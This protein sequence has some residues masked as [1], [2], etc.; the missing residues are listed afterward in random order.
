MFALSSGVSFPTCP[1]RFALPYHTQTRVS[2][3]SGWLVFAVA[4]GG[5]HVVWCGAG[6]K[7]GANRGSEPS[8]TADVLV[9]LYAG[10]ETNF[11][12]GSGCPGARSCARCRSRAENGDGCLDRRLV[13]GRKVADAVVFGGVRRLNGESA[14]KCESVR[15]HQGPGESRR[16]THLVDEILTVLQRRNALDASTKA[17][18]VG[19]CRCSAIFGG[20]R[21]W[22][23][24][25]GVSVRD[26]PAPL[27]SGFDFLPVSR[28]V[29]ACAS[30][31]HQSMVLGLP[32]ELLRLRNVAWASLSAMTKVWEVSEGGALQET[33]ATTTTSSC[34]RSKW[35]NT[36]STPARTPTACVSLRHCTEMVRI[37]MQW[38]MSFGRLGKLGKDWG[39]GRVVVDGDELDVQL[40]RGAYLGI[41]SWRVIPEKKE[42]AS[43]DMDALFNADSSAGYEES[44]LPPRFSGET[45]H[46]HPTSERPLRTSIEEYGTR[47]MLHRAHSH[48][49]HSYHSGWADGD[50]AHT[51]CTPYT[52]PLGIVP[53]RQY[54]SFANTH[55]RIA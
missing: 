42:I 31:A 48:G 39:E 22:S 32:R 1:Y 2:A 17:G 45:T 13:N 41:I 26:S 50:I 47:D 54:D 40:A 9:P 10:P 29:T 49:A 34:R 16:S 20:G 4:R 12:V 55:V 30:G 51:L 28:M 18:L 8:P 5:A 7:G 11:S 27:S 21:G 25:L 35:L 15:L 52:D 36:P 6:K 24:T 19:A 3:G 46:S 38:R 37:V 44:A 33:P 43:E 23:P 53:E 14:S